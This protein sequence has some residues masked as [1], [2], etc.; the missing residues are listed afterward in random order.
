VVVEP[1]AVELL[2]QLGDGGLVAALGAPPKMAIDR[3]FVDLHE[4][5]GPKF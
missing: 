3:N 5:A 1:Q 2:A 4:H